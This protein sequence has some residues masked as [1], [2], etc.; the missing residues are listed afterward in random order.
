MFKKW[1][2]KIRKR[3]EEKNSKE[4]SRRNLLREEAWARIDRKTEIMLSKKCPINNGTNCSKKCVNFSDGF[5]KG[6]VNV[7]GDIYY[8]IK[9]PRCN[10]WR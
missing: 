9:G 8:P 7:E 3:K 1:Y 10:L 6:L 2:D 4:I 5:T